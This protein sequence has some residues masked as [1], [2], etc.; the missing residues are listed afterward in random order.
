[1]KPYIVKIPKVVWAVDELGALDAA[2]NVIQR[3]DA[4]TIGGR[5]IEAGETLAPSSAFGKQAWAPSGEVAARAKFGEVVASEA[6]RM[7]AKEAA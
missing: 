3:H 2:E 4:Y 5:A 1:M 7:A 6:A